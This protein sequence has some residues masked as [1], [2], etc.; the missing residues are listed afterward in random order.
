MIFRKH[1]D[2]KISVANRNLGIIIRTFTYL[3]EEIFMTLYKAVVKP[4]VWLWSPLYKKDKL[5]L[6][7]VQRRAKGAH[8][9]G[10]A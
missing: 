10:K 3:S 2:N 5:Q 6:E 1:I 8:L 4:K 9:L 7:N